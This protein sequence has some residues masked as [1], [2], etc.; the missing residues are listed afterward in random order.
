MQLFH[1][2]G[3]ILFNEKLNSQQLPARGSST[4]MV[5]LVALVSF[6]FAAGMARTLTSQEPLLPSEATLPAIEIADPA[7]IKAQVVMSSR[8]IPITADAFN[9]VRE[10]QIAKDTAKLLKLAIALKA[11]LDGS[12]SD[13][14]SAGALTKAG[15]IEKLA[16]T[17]KKQY[18]E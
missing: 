12:S 5:C 1:R 3:T 8:S 16:K 2:Q 9:R 18:D 10:K 13:Q 11:E 14:P 4:G 17:R 7:G 6:G 15:E